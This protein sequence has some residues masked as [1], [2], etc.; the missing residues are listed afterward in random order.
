MLSISGIASNSRKRRRSN[1]DDA[2]DSASALSR[3]ADALCCENLPTTLPEPPK[4]D[5]VGAFLIGLGNQI[6]QL[7][8]PVQ[9]DLLKQLTDIVYE[10]VKRNQ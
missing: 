3:I 8:Q 4:I 6:R 2:I 1:K 7:P 10:A 9:T 5:T